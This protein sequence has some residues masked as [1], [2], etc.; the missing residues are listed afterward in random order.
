MSI[1]AVIVDDATAIRVSLPALI[2][3]VTF[4]DSYPNAEALLAA[5][6]EV[7]LVVL[8]LH[9]ANSRQP[10][11]H[12]GIAAIRSLI[13]ADY[14]VCVYT[15]EERRFVLAACVAAGALGVVSKAASLDEARQAFAEV[16]AGRIVVPQSLIGL[17]EVL[18]RRDCIT[19]LGP[20]QREVLAGRARGQTYA[21]MSKRMYLA[22]STL[23]GYW[24]ELSGQVARYLQ[25]TAPGDI[26]HAL[27]LGPG[28]LLAHWPDEESGGEKDWWRA[29]QR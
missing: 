28:D 5:R 13:R 26:E 20:R 7:D 9:L 12:Q 24:Q 18:V 17:M 8:D 27:G 10:E 15:Q 16:A 6:P 4:L 14:R 22:E 21:E 3:E 19:L 2:P 29:A 25:Q 11:A 1:T 23:R